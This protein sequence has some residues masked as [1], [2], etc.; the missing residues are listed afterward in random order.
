M[1]K[2]NVSFTEMSALV[3][4]SQAKRV[5]RIDSLLSSTHKDILDS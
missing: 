3:K 5:Y 2:M 1:P 4:M